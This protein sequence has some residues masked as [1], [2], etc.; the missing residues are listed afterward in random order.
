[1]MLPWLA[2][3]RWVSSRRFTSEVSPGSC[4]APLAVPQKHRS[5]EVLGH[6]PTTCWRGCCHVM[7]GR[8]HNLGCDVSTAPQRVLFAGGFC[9][10]SL[11]GYSALFSMTFLQNSLFTLFSV[12]CRSASELPRTLGTKNNTEREIQRG[13]CC[14]GGGS[15]R[16]WPSCLLRHPGRQLGINQN[17]NNYLT[18]RKLMSRIV[19]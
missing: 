18:T 14:P 9:I 15:A 17:R 19:V 5:L 11:P 10:W 2:A 1:M 7:F 3:H 4:R 13:S 16:R 12:G 8:C 6:F